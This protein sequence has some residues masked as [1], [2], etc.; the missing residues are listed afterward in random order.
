MLWSCAQCGSDDCSRCACKARAVRVWLLAQGPQR[1]SEDGRW[2]CGE[3]GRRRRLSTGRMHL[4]HV[5]ANK[6]C[7]L[8]ALCA[9]LVLLIPSLQ[10][11]PRLLDLPRPAGA[12]RR[13][14]GAFVRP[15]H[16]RSK[17]SSLDL[18]DVFIAVK[19]TRKYHQSRLQLLAQ[20]WVSRAK[21]QVGGVSF[22]CR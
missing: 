12:V 3:A 17:D 13:S 15:S 14:P 10:P 21:E 22:V 8:L 19:T 18:R 2:C 7:F 4:S 9:L 20:T 1:C 5:C 6:I 11:P 16:T